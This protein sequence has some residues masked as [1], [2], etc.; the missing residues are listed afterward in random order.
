MDHI[1]QVENLVTKFHTPE[2]VVHAVNGVSFHISEGETLA[3]VGESGCGKTVTMLSI[4]RL[5]PIPPGEISSSS[6][7]FF[8]RDLLHLTEEEMESIRGREI[9]MIFQDSMTSLNPVLTIGRQ[10]TESLIIH[11]GYNQEK[12]EQRAID[13]MT[14][15]GIPEAE[16]RLDDYPHQFSGGMRQRVM[17]AMALSCAPSLVIADEPTTALDV[18][19]QSQIIELVIRLREE[20]GMSII[21]IT[22]DLGVVAGLADR[23]TVMYSGIILE[24]SIVDNIY[25]N[26]RHPYTQ[27]LLASLP[28]VDQ[29]S[30]ELLHSIPGAPPNL[31]IEPVC[32]P[33]A[34][35]CDYVRDKCK[36]QIP[37]LE[38]VD[39]NH[40]V[41]C[42]VDIETGELK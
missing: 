1:L 10:M 8:N 17:I 36:Q 20:L 3:V 35:R 19:I 11:L 38:L 40:K 15:V 7:K 21:W 29:K 42:W 13:M 34:P 18:T 14:A 30:H 31:L 33:F 25:E 23:V 2:G 37:P 6:A 9:S 12:A 39:V 16:K 26:P 32:C 41:A 4:L 22:H 5:I 27:A 28:R 24:E